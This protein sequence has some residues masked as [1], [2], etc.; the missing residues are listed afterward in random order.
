MIQHYASRIIT[1]DFSNHRGD[2]SGL[3]KTSAPIYSGSP[4][5]S[6]E[7]PRAGPFSFVPISCTSNI[8]LAAPS[9]VRKAVVIPT[10]L[11]VVESAKALL[12]NA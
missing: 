1:A 12:E 3:A 9:Q 5:P 8:K 11:P 7:D 6:L 4:G 10:T 2:G